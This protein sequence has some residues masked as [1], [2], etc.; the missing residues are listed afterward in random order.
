MTE[1]SR[2]PIKVVDR[3]H[4]TSEGERRSSAPAEPPA[5]SAPPAQKPRPEAAPAPREE[6][7]G[8]PT[9]F[10]GLVGFLAESAMVSLRSGAGPAALGQYIDLLEMLQVKT[11][12]NLTARE[13]RTLDET[14]GG[15]KLVFL[16]VQKPR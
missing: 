15:L 3:R 5:P 10:E 11:R 8:T 1:G 9:M 12:G 16:K 6:S 4:F 7:A 13:S 2:E 14:L